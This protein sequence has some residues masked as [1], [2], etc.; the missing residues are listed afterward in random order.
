[1][2]RTSGGFI[3]G[4]NQPPPN[5]PDVD[6]E[7]SRVA[8]ENESGFGLV[9][10]LFEDAK[11]ICW[12]EAQQLIKIAELHQL[13]SMTPLPPPA[14]AQTSAERARRQLSSLSRE[15]LTTKEV[16]ARLCL[17]DYAAR[18]LVRLAL[19]LTTRFTGTLEALSQGRLDLR[20]AE[21]IDE[22]A[23]PLAEDHYGTA[24]AKGCSPDE[25]ERS[26][27][28]IAAMVESLVLGKASTQT[29]QQ[30][31]PAVRRAV[32]RLDPG[33]TDRQ[34]KKELKCR[35]VTHRTNLADGSGDLYA[36][37][38]AAE[39]Q[40]VYN[41][42]D[43]YA[44]AARQA[45]SERNLNELRA[46]ALTHLV[47]YGHMPDN[48]PA[49]GPMDVDTNTA[50]IVPD[51]DP[52][53]GDLWPNPSDRIPETDSGNE[54]IRGATDSDCEPVGTAD[55]GSG[56]V[57][58]TDSGSGSV[59][60]TESGSGSVGSA[61]SG[62]SATDCATDPARPGP[63]AA[64]ENSPVA[65]PRSVCGSG[66]S[67]VRA[68]VQVVISLETLLGL[69]NDPADLA[70]HGPITAQTARDLAFN[71][72]STWRRLVTDP[73]TG[74]LLNYGRKTYRPPVAL[75]DHVRVRDLTCRTP[76]CTRPARHCDLDHIVSW[77]AGATSER[78]LAAECDRDHRYKHEGNWRHQV[79][80]DPK[81]PPG[82][83]VMISPT[84]HIY[85]SYPHIY[86][87]PR[88]KVLPEQDPTG[89]AGRPSS[90]RPS[91]KPAPP[92]DNGPPPF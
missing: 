69:N 89:Q 79:S 49:T 47:L 80:A 20:R 85:L 37:L 50:T 76:N 15:D 51:I 78:N 84:G 23:G 39:A 9:Q 59:G 43:A 44:R 60:A 29:P 11:I 24:I 46:D 45:G 13:G 83:I 53:T 26:A 66:R 86:A 73:V 25:A 81:H 33:F 1:M 34:V 5:P 4:G 87:D 32:H 41:V 6:S 88:P 12:F 40:G 58:A 2:T 67:G 70:G 19:S 31:H 68:H 57:G 62:V 90:S 52:D 65:D 63:G 30:L 28:S 61:D 27:R 77:P 38:G 18:R 17:S 21:I 14:A 16:A 48:S 71:A 54:S 91:R 8:W 56:S 3:G 82:T 74:Y 64:D 10:G 7:C 72:G 22:H 92:E 42:V 55:S 75:A 35:Q 36:H